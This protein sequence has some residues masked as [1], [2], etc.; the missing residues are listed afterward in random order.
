MRF[1]EN[2]SNTAGEYLAEHISANTNLPVA[3]TLFSSF[4]ELKT[5]ARKEMELARQIELIMRGKEIINAI[6]AIQK[7]LTCVR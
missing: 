5:T 2:N 1:V 7:K 3:S 6:D 4:A